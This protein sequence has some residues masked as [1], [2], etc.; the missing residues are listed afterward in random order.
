MGKQAMLYTAFDFFVTAYCMV[1][2]VK[3][4]TTLTKPQVDALYAPML[5]KICAVVLY[6]WMKC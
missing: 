1:D 5:I 2:R 4:S 3:K 6:V